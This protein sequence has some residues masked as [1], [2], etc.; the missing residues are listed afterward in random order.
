MFNNT[1]NTFGKFFKIHFLP[2]YFRLQKMSK[3]KSL[4]SEEYFE[5]HHRISIKWCLVK[6]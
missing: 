3:K 6:H 5:I 4:L 2:Y 1:F